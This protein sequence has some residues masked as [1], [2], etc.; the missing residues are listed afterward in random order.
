MSACSP[1][2]R[3]AHTTRVGARPGDAGIDQRVQDLPLRLTQP[4]HHRRGQRGEQLLGA[5]EAGAPRDVP[6]RSGTAP[7]GRSP[8]AASRVSSRKRAMRPDSAAALRGVVVELVGQR[9]QLADDDDLVA[10]DGH[11]RRAG[12]PV[13]GQ[14]AREPARPRRTA[15]GT[16][17]APPRPRPR[18]PKPRPGPN[19]P[20]KPPRPTLAA[21]AASV[22]T[23]ALTAGG[24]RIAGAPWSGPRPSVRSSPS[25][26][27]SFLLH[28]RDYNVTAA[29]TRP[30][31]SIMRSHPSLGRCAFV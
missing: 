27:F 10:V 18:G 30:M 12:E 28:C 31:L 7:D 14:P 2:R 23:A 19:G 16:S 17:G 11:G 25:W 1:T 8:S 4:G 29:R 5:A 9:R 6:G 13:L 3:T 21:A 26:L 20:P 22:R 15:S 24:A